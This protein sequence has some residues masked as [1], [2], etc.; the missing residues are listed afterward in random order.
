MKKHKI[1]KDEF[2]AKIYITCKK[3]GYNNEKSRYFKYGKCL[4]CGAILDEK[5]YFMIQMTKRLK[6]NKRRER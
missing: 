1:S 5:T 2:I 4:K 3:C 6:D